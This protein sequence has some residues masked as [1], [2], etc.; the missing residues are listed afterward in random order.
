[1]F[2]T[3]NISFSMNE[4]ADAIVKNHIKLLHQYNEAKD[5]TQVSIKSPIDIPEFNFLIDSDWP[6]M[7]KTSNSVDP[8]QLILP[9]SHCE[10]LHNQADSRR[11]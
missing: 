10:G 3:Q 7:V 4:S 1:M 8:V 2:R 6:C 9:A 11:V 5:A